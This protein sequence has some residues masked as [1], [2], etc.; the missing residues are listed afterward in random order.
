MS[1][2]GG[3]GRKGGITDRMEHGGGPKE[4][5]G[6]ESG[7]KGHLKAMHAE[8]GGKHMHVHQHEGGYTTHHVK[9]DGNVEGPHDHENTE[10]LKSHMDRFFNEEEHEPASEH[11]HDGLM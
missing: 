11:E 7:V 2:F 1:K 4:H 10:Q 5:D 9:D 3:G 8:H 6:E